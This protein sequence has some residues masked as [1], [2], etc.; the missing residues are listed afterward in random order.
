VHYLARDHSA[1]VD[2]SVAVGD[3]REVHDLEEAVHED[4]G[5]VLHHEI[6][7]GGAGRG[8]A[9]GAP[10]WG[11]AAACGAGRRGV[12]AARLRDG[13]G[14]AGSGS[15]AAHGVGVGQ[16][17][18]ERMGIGL[19]IELDFWTGLIIWAAFFCFDKLFRVL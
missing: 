15:E 16:R 18:V 6:S 14:R 19:D 17:R 4:L 5:E 3:E 1:G 12:G 11:G 13:L 10:G 7:A 2:P 8:W 9:G